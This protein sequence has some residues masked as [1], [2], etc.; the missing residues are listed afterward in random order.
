MRA[1]R[2]PILLPVVWTGVCLAQADR[3]M[4]AGVATDAGGAAIP[5]VTVR[6]TEVATNRAFNAVSNESGDF[7]LTSLPLGVYRVKVDKEGFQSVV[8]EGVRIDAGV[9]VRLDTKLALGAVQQTVVVSAEGGAQLQTDDAKVQNVVPDELIAGLPTVVAGQMRSPFDLAGIT[10]QV[11]GGDQDFRIGGGQQGAFGVTLDGASANT[12]RAGSTTWAAVNAPSLDAITQF[13]VETNGFKAEFGRAGGGLVSFVSKSGT[14]QIHGT[15]FDFIRNNAF[16]ARGFFN[17]VTP[18]Y[19]QHDFGGTLGGPVVIPKLYNGRNRTFFFVSYEGF[20]NRVGGATTFAALPPKEFYDGDFRN[21]VS[22][23]RN[24]DGSYIMYQVYDPATT[25]FDAERNQYTRD[26]FPENRVPQARFDGITRKVIDLVR[27]AMTGAFRTD[28]VPGTPQYWLENYWQRGTSVNPNDKLSFKVDHT[29]TDRHRLSAY[30][31][32]SKRTGVPGPSGPPGIPGIMNPYTSPRNTS[33][34]WR[35]SWDATVSPRV[36]NRFFFGINNFKDSN[37]HLSEGGNWKDKIC[38]P[39]APDCNRNLPIFVIGDFPQWGGNGF[40]GSENPVYSFNDDISFTRGKHMFKGGY[41]YEYSPYVGLGQ[42]NGA[43]LV[44]FTTAMTNLPAQS[45]RNVG[46]GMGF[47]SF[48]LGLGGS[49]TIHTP[50][51]V[52]MQWKYHAMYFQDD[53]RVTPKLTLNLG[54]RYEFNEPAVNDGDKC[55][56]FDPLAPNPGA[57]GRPGALVFCG[58]GEGRIG[59]RSI[60]PGWYGGW[61]PRFGLSWMAMPRTVVRLSAGTSYA[62]V[63]SITGSGHFQGFAL[64]QT[65]PDQTGGIEPVMKLDQGVPP[66]PKPPFIDPTFSNNADVDWWQ[67]REANRLP[68]NWSWTLTVQRETKFNLLVEAGYSA[69]IGTHLVADLLEFNQVD[70]NQLPANAS[71][72]TASGRALLNT[73]FGNSNRLVTNAGF[74]KPYREFPDNLTLAR[75]LKPFPQ[76]NLV[77]T[78]N[79][80]DHSGH[81]SYHS[82]ILKV[83][84]RFSKGLVIDSSYVFSKMLT[85]SDSMW[86]TDTS[87]DHYNRRLEKSLSG[88]DRTHEGKI[89][90]VYELPVGRGKPWLKKGFL[91]QTIGGWR[92]GSVHRYASGAPLAFGGQFGFPIIG[93]RPYISTYD[94]WRAPLTGNKFDPA[95]DRYFKT[96]TTATWSGDT[97]TIVEEGFFP[98]QPRDR[99]GNMTRYN[100]KARNFPILNE[101]VSLA[102]QFFLTKERRTSAELRFEAFNLLN[103]TQFGTP[104]TNLNDVANL[105][106]VRSQ[107]NTPRRMQFALK[108]VW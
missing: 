2:M 78:R 36:H 14:N 63:K 5:G 102:K 105:G 107:A 97:A 88:Q 81:S 34:V 27:P 26:P 49:T 50:R 13:T 108:F 74:Q 67:G 103:R 93:N 9:T 61:G 47:A 11:N 45:N 80:G 66:W 65:F 71:I 60:P 91:A 79:G 92:I 94:G 101:N 54:L 62:P 57:S 37:L 52:G 30:Y 64:I 84:R 20:R 44:N 100:P 29:L 42:Q 106:L 4:I 77:N 56:D 43:G 59:R 104:N 19:R 96:P 72:F 58:M 21:A 24:P 33:P 18:V 99:I 39:N 82:L 10:A 48:L 22:R 40:N 8:H 95:V 16:D 90:Y 98:L 87:V 32:Y 85:D 53:W 15:A 69:I 12:N 25:R 7:S 89:N 17:F 6:A 38:I 68:Q 55:A 75:A 76:Y 3:G 46:G 73:T 70:I 51:R 23:T 86:G 31:A 28:V 35:G 41:M 83:T 1:L